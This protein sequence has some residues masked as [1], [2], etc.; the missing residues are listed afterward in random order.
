MVLSGGRFFN[1]SCVEMLRV[2]VPVCIDVYSV[3]L[4][5]A[6]FSTPQFYTSNPRLGSQGRLLHV[7]D[8]A[9]AP[10]KK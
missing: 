8:G 3:S 1:C 6:C 9:N 5:S 4:R 7:N 10:W 2:Q